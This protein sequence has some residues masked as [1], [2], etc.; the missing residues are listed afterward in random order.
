MRDW[1]GRRSEPL[2]T[3]QGV[4]QIEQETERNGG[5]QR[6]VKDHDPFLPL[7]PLTGVGIADREREKA[8][9][10]GD[11]QNVHHLSFPLTLALVC[12]DHRP[13]QRGRFAVHQIDRTGVMATPL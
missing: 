5:G 10:E 12:Y 7:E 1:A 9:R 4:S 2:G 3:Q 13:F 8:E 11:H 6:I